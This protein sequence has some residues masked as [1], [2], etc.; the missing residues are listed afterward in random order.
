MNSS[1]IE[2][3]VQLSMLPSE[4]KIINQ[5]INQSINQ[6]NSIRNLQLTTLLT[7]NPNRMTFKILHTL[8][9]ENYILVPINLKYC[10]IF[11]QIVTICPT[12]WNSGTMILPLGP[13]VLSVVGRVL[14]VECCGLDVVGRVLWVECCGLSVVG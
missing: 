2:N 11:S 5:S 9:C 1:A 12:T 6:C 14:W 10:N 8:Y 3:S 13:C 4:S 7:Y